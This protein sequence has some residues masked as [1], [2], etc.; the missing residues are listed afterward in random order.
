MSAAQLIEAL[1]NL[2]EAVESMQATFGRIEGKTPEDDD[3][4]IHDGWAEEFLQER[5][6]E[7]IA[8]VAEA[9]GWPQ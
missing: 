7:A 8:A 5:K 6:A 1:S 2:I 9:Q 4:Y 3:T